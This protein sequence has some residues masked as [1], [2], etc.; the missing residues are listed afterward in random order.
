MAT[1][2]ENLEVYKLAV[3]LEVFLYKVLDQK[4]PKDEK[5]RSVDQ[6]KRSSSSIPDN[7]AESYGKY[8]YGAKINH[9]YIARGETVETISGIER[10]Y[11]KG[12]ISKKL[13]LFLVNKY[14]E[15]LKR[16]NSYI[17]FVKKQQQLCN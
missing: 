17:S 1:G 13:T 2:L 15:L 3:R 7:V 4:F 8:S 9:L 6:L 16:L 14:T 10:A 5:Y 11:L 12:F